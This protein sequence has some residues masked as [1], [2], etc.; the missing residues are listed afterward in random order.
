M[1]RALAHALLTFL[2]GLLF[3]VASFHLASAD[4]PQPTETGSDQPATGDPISF[5]RDVAP[6]LMKNCLACHG[7]QEPKGEYQ[8]SSYEK[9]MKEG[10][11]GSPV[12]TP[13]KPEES[14]LLRLVSSEDA[15]ERMP[16]EADPLPAEAVER[17]KRWIEQGAKYDADDPK[18]PLASIVPQARHPDPPTVYRVAVPVTAL[19][20]GPDGSRLASSG[21][22]EI[23]LWNP[24][25]G[26]LIS[27][28]KDVAERTY[29]LAFS[30]DGTLLAAASGTPGQLGEVRLFSVADGALV[31][32]LASLPDAAFGVAFSP[33]GSRLAACGADRSIRIFDVASGT[34]QVLIEDHADWV[35]AIAFS[36]DGAHLASASRDKTAKVFDAKTGESVLTYP[37]HN[38]IVYAVHF[39]ADGTQVL[40]CGRDK[41]V[42][43]WQVSD[44]KLLGDIGG[45]GGD[46][47]GL[48]VEAGQIF[49]CGADRMI[50]QHEIEKRNEVRGYAG[51][52][53]WVYRIAYHDPTK[54]L[55]SGAYDGEI[56]V[57]NVADG[58]L[59]TA[60]RGAPGFSPPAGNQQAAR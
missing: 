4:E 58:S 8:L 5:K 40:S 28:I 12:I 17:I 22:H 36:P 26:A 16:K 23:I 56:R 10:Y 39:N 20:F 3:C 43:L 35:L 33:D 49:T 15:D 51:H 32:Q 59:V 11:S 50:R 55:A 45:F 9:L 48:I 30:P 19:A 18:A 57:W 54:R 29:G 31:R 41:K 42:H 1:P 21:Y 6:I 46:V 25:D 7:Q 60:F 13:G 53:D 47:F 14:E 27:R 37:G 38:E 44:G 34:Q 2:L 52:G 24:S